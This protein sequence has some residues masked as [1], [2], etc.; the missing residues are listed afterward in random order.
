MEA[1]NKAILVK[2]FWRLV[3]E[4][5]SL[6]AHLLKSKYFPNNDILNS[7]M[8]PR[9]SFAWRSIIGV[10]DIIVQGNRWLVGDGAS[11]NIW[12]SRWIP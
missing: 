1:F 6:V 7:N 11:L 10:K 2:Q 4:E 8:G 5:N 9:S 3:K 12:E